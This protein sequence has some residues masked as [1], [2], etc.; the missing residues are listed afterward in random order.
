MA[1]WHPSGEHRICPSVMQL[2]MRGRTLQIVSFVLY[3]L[4]R[5]C[6]AVMLTIGA[7]H[8]LFICWLYPSAMRSEPIPLD[9]FGDVTIHNNI[10]LNGFASESGNGEWLT[11]VLLW[12]CVTKRCHRT[13]CA[14]LPL[15]LTICR[16]LTAYSHCLGCN[17]RIP[18]LYAS[19]QFWGGQAGRLQ[20][21]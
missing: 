12:M 7:G 4:S 19:Y 5:H 15:N 18:C 3:L 11:E 20:V 8:R 9:I 14:Q 1:H 13:T 17:I 10:V 16:I 6:F 21:E 2:N